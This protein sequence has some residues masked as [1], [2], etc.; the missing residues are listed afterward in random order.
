MVDVLI[1]DLKWAIIGSNDKWEAAWV[2]TAGCPIRI[3]RTTLR[4]TVY[5]DLYR[6]GYEVGE[7]KHAADGEFEAQCLLDYYIA[8]E[9]K[10]EV[11]PSGDP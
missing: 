10:S 4:N 9:N 3:A 11:K 2:P 8:L 7:C 6:F 5:Q 1:R